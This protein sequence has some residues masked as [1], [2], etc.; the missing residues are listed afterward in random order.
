MKLSLECI[1]TS[2][3]SNSNDFSSIA[4]SSFVFPILLETKIENV[5]NKFLYDLK[6]NIT[7][8]GLVLNFNLLEKYFRPTIESISIWVK[9]RLHWT[10]SN[11]NLTSSTT[12][13]RFQP[14][15]NF[16]TGCLTLLRQNCSWM[17]GLSWASYKRGHARTLKKLTL[18][19][20]FRF[21]AIWYPQ[22]M[23]KNSFLKHLLISKKTGTLG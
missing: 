9:V 4:H 21:P 1:T 2:S 23:S 13:E 8:L 7:S 14:V 12:C 22:T 19:S 16:A 17:V 20:P 15:T 10:R 18:H 6:A 5:Y 3:S 11:Q